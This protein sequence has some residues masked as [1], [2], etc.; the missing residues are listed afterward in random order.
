[1]A[2]ESPSS[3]PASLGFAGR[4]T[5]PLGIGI[6]GRAALGGGSVRVDLLVSAEWREALAEQQS[7]PGGRGL[8]S[9]RSLLCVPLRESIVA[10][11]A[12]LL[13]LR[14][15]PEFRAAVCQRSGAAA[16]KP[17]GA[18]TADE[19]AAVECLARHA[20]IILDALLFQ[21]QT[22][23]AMGELGSELDGL[24]SRWRPH[25]GLDRDYDR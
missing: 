11:T 6:V 13:L 5:V 3:G 19:Q 24:K 14:H 16:K 25:R 21:N 7:L 4:P 8:T 9:A 2:V 17:G 15:E 23:M 1:M 10:P 18:F 22:E 20:G 12:V